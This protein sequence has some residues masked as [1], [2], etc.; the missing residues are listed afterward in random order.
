M[1][2]II[3]ANE[4]YCLVKETV[5]G[6]KLSACWSLSPKLIPPIRYKECIENFQKR[7]SIAVFGVTGMALKED[8]MWFGNFLRDL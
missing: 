2:C 6:A 5:D 1:Y 4:W 8:R 7:I 3:K